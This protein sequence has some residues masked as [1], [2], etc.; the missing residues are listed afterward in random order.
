MLEKMMRID[1]FTSNEQIVNEYILKNFDEI[2]LMTIYDLAD[3]TFVSPATIVRYC[4][5]LGTDG[6][7]EF[8]RELLKRQN[9]DFEDDS[10]SSSSLLH[11]D[12]NASMID[13]SMENL[14]ITNHIATQTSNMLNE[15]LLNDVI[16]A[17]QKA[18]NIYGVGVG[19]SFIL[20]QSLQLKLIKL[21]YNIQL[22]SSQSEQF[23]LAH[24]STPEDLA[25][26]ISY[27]GN[28][29]EIAND[30]RIFHKN[31]TS[32]IAI[33]SNTNS[34]LESYATYSL[35]MPSIE[36]YDYINSNFILDI[37]VSYLINILYHCLNQKTDH[38]KIES[39]PI[40]F[41]EK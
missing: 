19:N 6:F 24:Y 29:A 10:E 20:L 1:N 7:K 35:Y 13:I 14:R 11:L 21:G 23:Y 25:I 26:I 28:T 3:K 39:T 34:L 30:A 22:I 16:N 36:E 41:F 2:S 31:N 32:I 38:K 17:L 18:T 5:K 27:S 37:S 9:K 33:T 12:T 40:S 15:G 4:K 8:R